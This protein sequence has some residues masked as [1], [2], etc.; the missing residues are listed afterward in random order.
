MGRFEKLNDDI[1]LLADRI[2]SNQDLCRLIHYP[3]SSP[4]STDLVNVNGKRDVMDKRLILFRP[5]LPLPEET[6]SYLNI[7]TTSM[8][9]SRGDYYI[10][11]VLGFCIYCHNN[12]RDIW[13]EDSAG[14]MKKGDRALL[15]IDRIEGIIKDIGIGIGDE[16]FGGVEEIANRDSSFAG[17]ALSY[18]NVDFRK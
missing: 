14:N 7:R 10:R 8:R 4:L 3:D 1:R 16:N 6:G 12:V 9:S 17:Y 13:Y 15:I 18:L 11:T 2:L 5:K